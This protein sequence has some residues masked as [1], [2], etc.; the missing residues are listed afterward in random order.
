V[1]LDYSPVTLRFI[2]ASL[3]GLGIPISQARSRAGKMRE[4]S[5]WLV[6]LILVVLVLATFFPVLHNGFVLYDDDRNFLNN[7]SLHGLDW[8]SFRWAWTTTLLGVYQPLSWLLLQVQAS[9]WGLNPRGYHLVSL[10]LYALNTVVLFLLTLVILRKWRPDWDRERPGRLRWSAGLAVALFAVHPFRTEVVAWASCQP[11]MP[12]VL[13]YMLAVLAYLRG[14]ERASAAWWWGSFALFLA[15]LLFKGLAMSL[16]MVLLLLDVYLLRRCQNAQGA[17]SWSSWRRLIWEK[18]LFI[19]VDLVFVVIAGL[20]RE[21][22]MPLRHDG[23]WVRVSLLCHSICF[24]GYKTLLPLKLGPLYLLPR[25]GIS[26][27]YL[28][29]ISGVVA[30]FSLGVYYWRHRQS[31]IWAAWLSYLVMLAPNMG[32]IR[33]GLFVTADRYSYLALLGFVVLAAAGLF[34]LSQR[35]FCGLVGKVSLT[36][37]LTVLLVCAGLSWRQCQ[38]WHDSEALW[39]NAVQ[40]GGK[41]YAL[42][43]FYIGFILCAQGQ[44]ADGIRYLTRA[45]ELDPHFV[46]PR[47]AL[48]LA[49]MQEGDFA[50]ALPHLREAVRL[51]PGDAEITYLLGQTLAKLD[52]CQEAVACFGEALRLRPAFPEAQRDLGLAQIQLG[53]IDRAEKPLTEALRQHPDD[54]D[55][56]Y[57]LG[58]VDLSQGRLDEALTHFTTA[59]RLQPNRPD[60]HN[61]LGLIYVRLHQPDLALRHWSEALKLNPD[62]VEARK[63]LAFLLSEQGKAAEALAHFDRVLELRPNDAEALNG[64]G[65]GL[66]VT[67]RL[68]EAL[69]RFQEGVRL[70]PDNPD[71]RHNL[72]TAFARQGRWQEAAAEFTEVLRRHPDHTLSRQSLEQLRQ[73]QRQQVLVP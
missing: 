43:H 48:G 40:G 65:M 45:V 39:Q 28:I 53:Q 29:L 11:Y 36:L 21:G 52:R 27:L 44:D 10:L 24:Y 16:P 64:Q 12:C 73:L 32:F 4:R 7:S 59:L 19:A 71:M 61:N 30:I 5:T 46:E 47:K 37:S 41:D 63:N 35:W 62:F 25:T 33:C 22:T 34:V 49:L 50:R 8:S 14:F 42:G 1:G 38:T 60:A 66:A 15:A 3:G 31:G 54:A 68:T 58:Y 18:S 57:R 2:L 23:F 13:C 6:A 70:A 69:A 56:H 67:G 20:V 51:V 26:L 9:L 55:A 72:G 17:W